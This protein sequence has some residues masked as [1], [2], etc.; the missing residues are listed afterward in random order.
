M[1]VTQRLVSG[2]TSLLVGIQLAGGSPVLGLVGSRLAPSPS[3]AVPP[4]ATRDAPR[5]EASSPAAIGFRSAEQRRRWQLQGEGYDIGFDAQENR[6]GAPSLRLALRPGATYRDGAFAVASAHLAV[7]EARG[8]R[9]RLAGWVKS[10]GIDR[11][12]AGLW[13]RV[14]GAHG[15][16][17]FDNM[18]DRGVHGTTGWSRVEVD[19]DVPAEAAAIVLGALLTGD[20]VAWVSDLEVSLGS[21]TQVV[22]GTVID[23]AGRPVAGALVAAVV[24]DQDKAA[25][26]VRTV[27]DGSFRAVVPAG[28][29][30]LT[31]TA[32]GFVAT[33][34]A[35]SETRG[36]GSRRVVCRLSDRGP[37]LR[38]E[39]KAAG[40]LPPAGTRVALARF[41]ED[42]GG[43]YYG[44]LDGHGRFQ[45]GLPPGHYHVSLDSDAYAALS[46]GVVQLGDN[47][48]N[49]RVTFTASRLTAVPEEVVRWLELHVAPLRTTK[50]G[51]GDEDLRPLAAMVGKAQVVAL[52]EAT[53]GTREFFQLKHRVLEYL[54]SEMG[55]TV[56]AIEANWP[57]SLAID[58]YVLHG[59]GDAAQAL[60][61]LFYIWNTAEVLDM[62]EWMRAFN[63][64]A[65]HRHKVRFFGFDM[66]S[67]GLARG[68]VAAYL[69]RV[70]ARYASEMA[71]RLDGF[72]DDPRRAARAV[73]TAGL[74]TA[75][76]LVE[77]LD[78]HRSDYVARS[79]REEWE[80]V[81]QHAVILEQS[82]ALADPRQPDDRDR[83]MAD[84]VGWILGQQPPGTRMVLWGHN[85]HV[86]Y[87]K[88]RGGYTP[89]GEFLRRKL[90]SGYLSIGFLFDQGAFQA[91]RVGGRDLMG[92][93]EISVG[94]S[95][96]D[97]LAAVFHRTGLALGLLD[98]RSCPRS[99][100]VGAWLT[101]PHAVREAGAF[102]PGEPQ[103]WT[104][105][106]AVTERFDGLVYVD[107]TTRS[108]PVLAGTR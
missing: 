99:G 6:A 71:A 82:A 58:D 52:G 88:E 4:E 41:Q 86:N 38:G 22:E 17:A 14:D 76:A 80:L 42:G 74:A 23:P 18:G 49:P 26:V 98:L 59:K 97:S 57:E 77:R 87:G 47:D 50:P 37:Q 13:V 75:K 102:F 63:A 28:K 92:L 85:A 103:M 5:Q 89:M 66:Q 91:M 46:P 55:F 79:S 81:R 32:S 36:E 105:P 104:V 34:Q 30:T 33:S 93:H 64:D 39:L 35:L 94:P 108:R 106:T 7:E 44:E 83:A 15:V 27:G 45:L 31:A 8:K 25:A 43:F 62:I 20:G 48:L 3:R 56:F 21:V 53:H 68:A 2:L 84:N 51:Q 11:G 19:I 12:W 24:H 29:L 96:I 95:P 65:A 69:D 67:A 61:G 40:G 73:S 60:G 10:S 72:P 78:A 90:G 107:R 1:V 100:A 9:V 101:S 70:D 54:V 16:L